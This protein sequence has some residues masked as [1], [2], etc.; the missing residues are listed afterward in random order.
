MFNPGIGRNEPIIMRTVLA[1]I[2]LSSLG[3]ELVAQPVMPSA[4]PP[5]PQAVV[6]TSTQS[7]GTSLN[8]IL[9]TLQQATQT[10]NLDLTRLRIE[11][12]KADGSDKQEMQKMAASLQKNL[13]VAVP[14][15]ISDAQAAPGSVLKAFKLY[16]NIT[17]VYEYLSS[18]SEAAG[19]YGKKEEYE[20]LGRDLSAL[21]A[22][23][24][25]LSDYIE[26][27]ANTLETPRK[28]PPSVQAQPT[29]T[30]NKKIVIDDDAAPPK[31]TVK[32]KKP[33]PT[34]TPSPTPSQ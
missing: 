6:Q 20:P 22:A 11:K 1:V 19:A 34:P 16:D 10:A 14:G 33:S 17:I 29:P 13:T 12:W 25:N 32:K 23:R 9:S 18:L 21:D 24:R 7:A 26:Q 8:S 28:P 4:N 30:P 31:K 27:A 15:L 3:A 5:P 2:V